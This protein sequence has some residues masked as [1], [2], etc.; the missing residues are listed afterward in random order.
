[1]AH[2]KRQSPDRGQGEESVIDYQLQV[3]LIVVVCLTLAAGIVTIAHRN[4]NL[5]GGI[6]G[7]LGGWARPA[8]SEQD[9]KGL[10]IKPVAL[11]LLEYAVVVIVVAL[12]ASILVLL[13]AG[14]TANSI[15]TV[16]GPDDRRRLAVAALLAWGLLLINVVFAGQIIDALL[17]KDSDNPKKPMDR[18]GAGI[19]VL[20]RLLVVLLT[21]TAGP[22][23]I[24]LVIAAKSLARFRQLNKQGFAERYLVGTLASVTIALL[25]ALVAQQIWLRIA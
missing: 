11:L 2:R 14:E 10:R 25:S 23:S 21:L 5:L 22:A 17:P 19:G 24:S 1:M 13:F 12:A 9:G 18:M 16:I 7:R 3:G 15:S 20:E 6:A 4:P 8:D